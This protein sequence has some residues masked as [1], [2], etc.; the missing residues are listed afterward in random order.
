MPRLDGLVV[1]AH[2]ERVHVQILAQ[3]GDAAGSDSRVLLVIDHVLVNHGVLAGSTGA[4][5]VERP[6]AS[7]LEQARLPARQ[8]PQ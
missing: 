8:I 3:I 4:A 2:R 5:T 1:L 6:G 7:Q